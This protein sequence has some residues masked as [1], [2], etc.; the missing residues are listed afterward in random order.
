M[1]KIL[2]FIRQCI[3]SSLGYLGQMLGTGDKAKIIV[4]CY[5]SVGNSN[6]KYN[7]NPVVFKQQINQ[8]L[9]T[10][11]P[12]SLE[13]LSAYLSGKKQ[14][15]SPSFLLTFDDGYTNII[16]LASFLKDKKIKP[17]V[18]LLSDPSH[19][20]RTELGTNLPIATKKDWKKMQQYGWSIGSHSA[21][22]PNFS[23]VETAEAVKEIEGS[24]KVLENTLGQNISSIALPRG[25]HND[26]VDEVVKNVGYKMCLTM[27]DGIITAKTNP[28][29][30]PRIG[31][32]QTH[33][34]SEL[35]YIDSTVVI[36]LRTVLKKLKVGKLYE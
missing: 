1:K 16:E 25:N 35:R 23:Q 9:A 24:K 21:T 29:A 27:D 15:K 3:I 18:F 33:S 22:H 2:T 8:L 34:L 6:W 31:I 12:I 28:L 26:I 17:C 36:A 32:D 11:K 20:N 7:V 30:I 10:R 5:H 13:E 19:A 14:I 4:L